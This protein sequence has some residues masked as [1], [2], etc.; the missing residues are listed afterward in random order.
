MHLGLH[1]HA[2]GSVNEEPQL[3]LGRDG[4]VPP[5]DVLVLLESGQGRTA[6]AGLLR[7]QDLLERRLRGQVEQRLDA[8]GRSSSWLRDLGSGTSWRVWF[9]TGPRK[10]ARP[11]GV[12]HQPLTRTL[13]CSKNTRSR[14]AR[15]AR[16][17]AS[18]RIE[19]ALAL[20]HRPWLLAALDAVLE[21]LLAEHPDRAGGA[22]V[23]AGGRL[24]VGVQRSLGLGEEADV[25]GSS[26]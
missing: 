1:G 24:L 12:I 6:L 5:R 9:F 16:R 26:G 17:G 13:P 20:F 11:R 15:S 22:N 23:G 3:V 8:R 4:I 2:G 7:I 18:R 21:V 19:V 25:T 14:G 10:P